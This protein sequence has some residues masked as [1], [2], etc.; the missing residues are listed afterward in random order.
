MKGGTI[1]K[2][3]RAQAFCEHQ[4]KSLEFTIQYMMDYARV[5][6]DCV[7]AFLKKGEKSDKS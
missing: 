5:N 1:G 3:E 6:H 7:M 2:L 4:D